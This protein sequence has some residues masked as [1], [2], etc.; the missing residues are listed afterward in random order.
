[1]KVAEYLPFASVNSLR[2]AALRWRTLPA[3]GFRDLNA[4]YTEDT[5]GDVDAVYENLYI[6][7]GEVNFDRVFGMVVRHHY[8][9][10][11]TPDGHEINVPGTNFQRLLYQR[12]SR[13]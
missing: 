11:Q 1:M 6:L 13:Y 9:P 2:A 3:V 10:L 4:G 8:R 12:R 7:G 5:S